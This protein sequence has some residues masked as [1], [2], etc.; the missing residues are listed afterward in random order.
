MAGNDRGSYF[1]PEVGD[2]VLVAFEQGDIHHPYVIGALWNGKDKPPELNRD[3]KNNIRKMKSR[4]G[5]ELIFNDE[6]ENEQV[7]LHTKS[8][9]TVLLD[10]STGAEKIEI[11]DKSGSNTILID[12]ETKQYNH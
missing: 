8:G 5:H 4:S 12:S 3:G 1:L 9:H 10:D 2:E 7:V 11:K 6:N